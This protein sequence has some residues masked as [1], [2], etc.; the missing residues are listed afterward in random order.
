MKLK[1]KEVKKFLNIIYNNDVE[2][3]LEK[4]YADST[5]KGKATLHK[6]RNSKRVTYITGTINYYGS[7]YAI[8]AELNEK[9]GVLDVMFSYQYVNTY[10]AKKDRFYTI[11]SNLKN[12]QLMLFAPE[13]FKEIESG[14]IDVN[15]YTVNELL[16]K[17][18]AKVELRCE[19]DEEEKEPKYKLFDESM[20]NEL[21]GYDFE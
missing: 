1:V 16:N 14:E 20:D 9:T 17:V 7:L 8:T 12:G 11:Y 6:I 19:D 3:L 10:Y 18:F 4:V 13:D 21:E 5:F 15:C 2:Y